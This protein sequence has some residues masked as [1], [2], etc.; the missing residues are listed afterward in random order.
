MGAPSLGQDGQC[1]RA[2]ADPRVDRGHVTGTKCHGP[3]PIV[4]RAAPHR[5]VNFP[6]ENRGVAVG[7]LPPHVTERR[8]APKT[9]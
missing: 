2:A 8:L 6:G 5:L 3:V 7:Y 1:D 9:A 4:R